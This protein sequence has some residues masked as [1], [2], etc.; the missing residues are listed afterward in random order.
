MRAESLGADSRAVMVPL[1][2][3]RS[4]DAQ[5]FSAPSHFALIY[6]ANLLGSVVEA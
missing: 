1:L 6:I 2:L 3:S 5:N 4:L